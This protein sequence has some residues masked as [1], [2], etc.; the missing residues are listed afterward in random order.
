MVRTRLALQ[1][2]QLC[3][4]KGMSLPQR[5]QTMDYAFVCI[6]NRSMIA[7]PAGVHGPL[8]RLLH[9]K[10]RPVN[11]GDFV[12][13]VVSA[14]DRPVWQPLFTQLPKAWTR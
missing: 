6:R 8:T 11:L 9:L 10:D 1:R 12:R 14:P 5:L 7:W 4:E 13:D 3:A 2:G